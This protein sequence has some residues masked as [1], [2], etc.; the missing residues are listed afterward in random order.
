MSHH[1]IAVD[2]LPS[3][4]DRPFE[5]RTIDEA[6][7]PDSLDVTRRDAAFGERS[8]DADEGFVAEP[9]SPHRASDAE[10]AKEPVR[11][12]VTGAPPVDDVHPYE[13]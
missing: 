5:R 1:A 2:A 10:G 8:I 3:T 12:L 9:D 7:G 4:P 13:P 6:A 11:V